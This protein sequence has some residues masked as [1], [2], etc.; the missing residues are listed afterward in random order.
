[1]I[2]TTLAKR[3][4]KALVEIGQEQNAL[5]MYGQNLSEITQLVE[6]SK[7]F[8]ELLI[9]PVFTKEDKKKIADQILQTM[10][11]DP[12]VINFVNVLIDR[13]RIGQLAGIDMAFRQKV[14]EIHG[15]SRG[16]VVSADPLNKD[17]LGRVTDALSNITGKTVL[18]TSKVDPFLIGGLVAR[19]GDMVFDGSIRTQLNQLKESLKG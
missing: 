5:E 12:M 14:D 1:M 2:D 9:N 13:K 17:D 6:A 3:Y 4:A 10:G 16:E 18:V 8:R 7:D 19:V 15:I 11:T